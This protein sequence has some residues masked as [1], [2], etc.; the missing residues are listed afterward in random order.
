MQDRFIMLDIE[1]LGN[2]INPVI[3]QISAVEFDISTGLSKSE[4]NLH[5]EHRN[6]NQYGLTVDQSTI[7]WW[8]QQSQAAKDAVFGSEITY[9]LRY[10]L[11]LF[12]EYVQKVR[13]DCRGKVFLWG[14]GIRCDNVWLLSAYK[15]CGLD[16]P[17]KYNEDMDYRTLQYIAKHKTGHDFRGEIFQG[18]RH[19]AIDD[20]KYQI[21]CASAAWN[22][23]IN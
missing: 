14:N 7:A 11:E 19:N 15:A 20:C 3:A 4:F 12:T 17:I 5:I 1:T 16:D 9:D 6:Y 23:L 2:R 21:K 18:I 22:S 8:A 10:A 13:R